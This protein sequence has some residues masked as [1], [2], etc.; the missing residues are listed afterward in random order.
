MRA[1]CLLPAERPA[2]CLTFEALALA[3]MQVSRAD[4]AL[5]LADMQITRTDNACCVSS[6]C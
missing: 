1:A 3:D 2:E 6:A 4:N 5:A